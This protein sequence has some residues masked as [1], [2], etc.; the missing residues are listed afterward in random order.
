MKADSPEYIPSGAQAVTYFQDIVHQWHVVQPALNWESVLHIFP[1]WSNPESLASRIQNLGLVNCF[2]WHLEDEC[3]VNYATPLVLAKL[4]HDID[5]SNHRRVRQIDAIDDE[6]IL[7]LRNPGLEDR[8]A[9]LALTT[10]GNLMDRLSILVLKRYHAREVDPEKLASGLQT[11][12]L[13]EEQI[14]DLCTSID[15]FIQDLMDGRLCLKVYRTVKLYG[16]T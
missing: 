5:L 7:H 11:V 9:R 2:Q 16:S 3:R 4:K 14:T 1:E 6:F 13:L 8:P 15:E 10:P 12:R